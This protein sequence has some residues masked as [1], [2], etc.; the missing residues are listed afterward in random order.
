MSARSKKPTSKGQAP[1]PF[2]DENKKT[3]VYDS[4]KGK[5]SGGQYAEPDPT[6]V[7]GPLGG[8]K[9]YEKPA[10]NAGPTV[11]EK[12]RPPVVAVS[13]KEQSAPIKAISMKTPNDQQAPAPEK[14]PMLARPKLRAVSEV[15]P[16]QTPQNLG[17]LAQPYD[18][19]EARSRAMREYVIWGCVAVILASAIA[20]VVWFAAR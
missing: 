3:V 2:T 20:L 8:A 17:N 6:V 5:K 15:M 1:P 18:P 11:L 4:N 9:M 12:P 13:K 7:D 14:T 10:P 19:K 16:A